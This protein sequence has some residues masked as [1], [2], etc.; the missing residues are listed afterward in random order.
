[1]YYIL[2]FYL[3]LLSFLEVFTKLKFKR[4]LRINIGILILFTGFRYYNGVDYENYLGMFQNITSFQ[5]YNYLEIGFRYI[6]VIFKLLCKDIL[7]E[8][9]FMIFA[10]LGLYP[11]YLGIKNEYYPNFSLFIYYCIFLIDYNFNGVRQ[12]IVMGIYIYACPAIMSKK[13]IKSISCF[14]LSIL[15]HSSAVL[16]YFISFLI[17]LKTFKINF[18]K[19]S[20]IFLISVI[21]S[22]YGIEILKILPKVSNHLEHFGGTLRISSIIMRMM[23]IIILSRYLNEEENK[24]INKLY[25]VYIIGFFLY[26]LFYSV[27]LLSTRINMLFRVLEVLLIP[28]IFIREKNISKKFILFLIITAIISMPFFKNL[29]NPANYPYKVWIIKEKN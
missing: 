10:I 9:F 17:S 20:I 1:M 22:K 5:D 16:I 7:A 24:Y 4:L 2:Y 29:Q 11:V 27:G 15:F 21:I 6:I 26:G 13:Y 28:Q 19:I 3:G 25:N 14:F 23:L 12:S 8:N 18:K